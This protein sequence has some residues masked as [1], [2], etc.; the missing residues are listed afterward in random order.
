[1][2][3]VRI[4]DFKLSHAWVLGSRTFDGL[5][6]PVPTFQ[7]LVPGKVMAL[8]LMPSAGA[9]ES[10]GNGWTWFDAC[11]ADTLHGNGAVRCARMAIRSEGAVFG[12]YAYNGA[13]ALPMFL[14]TGGAIR[15]GLNTS[16]HFYPYAP[17]AYQIGSDTNPVK[18]VYITGLSNE[19]PNGGMTT[20][21]RAEFA[22]IQH[23]M[24]TLN[25]RL[26][27]LGG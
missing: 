19:M 16:G 7:P 14:E 15:W 10:P 26:I 18:D 24:A 4:E 1:M 9:V 21:I 22:K 23:Q 8:D 27:A 13:T 25:A 20:S 6:F 5:A 11:D 3:H 17:N 12:S 2:S